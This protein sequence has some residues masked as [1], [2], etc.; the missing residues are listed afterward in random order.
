MEDLKKQNEKENNNLLTS[1]DVKTSLE[2]FNLFH[3]ELFKNRD[4]DVEEHKKISNMTDIIINEVKN[5]VLSPHFWEY[6]QCVNILKSEIQKIILRNEFIKMP[7][8]VS[9]RVFLINEITEIAHN[10]YYK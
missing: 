7:N 4:L 8:I 9:K 1:S 3:K 10:K 2:V 6:P 5:N